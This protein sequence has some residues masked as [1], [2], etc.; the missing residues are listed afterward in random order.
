MGWHWLCF[1]P[2]RLAPGRV[3][4][5]SLLHLLRPRRDQ[6]SR[7][8]SFAKHQAPANSSGLEAVLGQGSEV[9][10]DGTS[11]LLM[12]AQFSGAGAQAE[13]VAME[14][15]G[16]IRLSRAPNMKYKC[17]LS[18]GA[19]SMDAA[20]EYFSRVAKQTD[21]ALVRAVAL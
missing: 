4:A 7:S 8:G 5:L 16:R 13:E 2:G 12:T 9:P 14:S 18:N 10:S 1:A 21:N 17:L 3:F 6:G 19:Q 20:L 15:A 11:L